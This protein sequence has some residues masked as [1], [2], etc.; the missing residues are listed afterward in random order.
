[1]ASERSNDLSYSGLCLLLGTIFIALGILSLFISESYLDS[2]SNTRDDIQEINDKMDSVRIVAFEA[3]DD[4]KTY[5]LYKYLRDPD[6]SVQ[7]TA[8]KLEIRFERDM[9]WRMAH[10]LGHKSL[11]EAKTKLGSDGSFPGIFRFFA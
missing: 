7:S 1:M 4:R 8:K 5:L 3:D 9:Y 11:D 6:R 2:V 10:Y